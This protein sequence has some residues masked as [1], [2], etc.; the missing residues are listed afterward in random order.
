MGGYGAASGGVAVIGLV[1]TVIWDAGGG[2]D[3][4]A[5]TFLFCSR[6]LRAWFFAVLGVAFLF[7][8]A[9]TA[10]FM[11]EDRSAGYTT[12]GMVPLVVP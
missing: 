5:R 2:A 7:I 9:A 12:N 6:F 1:G 3:A 11:R 8:A 10:E 4:R